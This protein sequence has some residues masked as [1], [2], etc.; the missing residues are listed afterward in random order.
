MPV[1]TRRAGRRVT[2][3]VLPALLVVLV[4]S[5][6][7]AT[8]QDRCP[9]TAP[10]LVG[11]AG[12]DVLIGTDGDDVI[13]GLGGDDVLRGLDG[14]DVLCGGGGTDRLVAGAGDDRVDPGHDTET[15]AGGGFGADRISFA[16]SPQA[17]EVDLMAATATGEGADTLVL[18]GP[19]EVVGSAYDDVLSGSDGRDDL[20]GGEGGDLLRG[21]QGDDSL[22]ADPTAY[23]LGRSGGDDEVHGGPGGDSIDLGNGDDQARGGAGRDS[24]VHGSGS[25]GLRGGPGRD[26]LDLLLSHASGQQVLGGGGRDTL[27]AWSVVDAD[28]EIVEA[29]GRIDL[30]DKRIRIVVDGVAHRSTLGGFEVLRVPN[31]TWRVTGTRQDETFYGGETDWSQLLVRAA[32][33]DDLIGGTPGDDRIHG[34]PGRDRSGDDGGR[35]VCV[36]IERWFGGQRCEIIR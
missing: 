7:S 28:D 22:E 3:P 5:P 8:V 15:D 19:V 36:S 33:G 9:S 17:V 26:H 23:R 16:G 18:E 29:H 2:Q 30:P 24:I 20:I 12:D 31:G 1:R 21:L 6:V 10:T 11:T 13:L 32:G 14:D 34:G 25:V 27:Y 35:D 4:M